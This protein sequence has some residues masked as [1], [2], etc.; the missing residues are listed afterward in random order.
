MSLADDPSGGEEAGGSGGTATVMAL[1]LFLLLLAFFILLVAISKFE[2]EKIDQVLF[3]LDEVFE[4]EP[5]LLLADEAVTN[6][7]G[8]QIARED[9]FEVVDKVFR[10]ELQFTRVRVVKQGDSMVI[11]VPEDGLFDPGS[12]DIRIEAAGLLG[13]VSEALTRPADNGGYYL[14][15]VIPLGRSA[16]DRDLAVRRAGRFA[17]GLTALNA[18]ASSISVG[19]RQRLRNEVHFFFEF[20]PDDAPVVVP[21]VNSTST[22]AEQAASE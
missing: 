15:M 21:V 14:D 18:P 7:D 19:V 16:G 17:R 4:V 6:R 11:A 13:R 1:A 2:S 10:D 12:S 9:F 3:S 22:S 8:S 5:E 20:R